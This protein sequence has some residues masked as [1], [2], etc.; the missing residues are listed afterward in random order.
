V[1]ASGEFRWPPVGRITWP[2][3]LVSHDL[4]RHAALTETL[5]AFLDLGGNHVAIAQRCHIH[6]STVKY[7]INRIA[8]ILGREPADPQVRFDLILAFKVAEL[9]GTLGQDLL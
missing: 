8:E 4:N 3:S 1:A 6:V 7:R 5:R 2:P 9:F